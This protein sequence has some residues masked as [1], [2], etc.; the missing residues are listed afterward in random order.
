VGCFASRHGF[1]D[2]IVVPS[3]FPLYDP[4]PLLSAFTTLSCIAALY[5][6]QDLVLLSAV[7]W[8]LNFT[9]FT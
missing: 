4:L 6:L 2:G 3:S 1:E 5:S 9:L 8:A 7:A